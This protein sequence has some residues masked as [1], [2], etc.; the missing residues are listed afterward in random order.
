MK[1]DDVCVILNIH[2]EETLWRA[3]W[4]AHEGHWWF[5]PIGRHGDKK[6]FPVSKVIRNEGPRT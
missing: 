4:K 5:K 6:V 2:G 3:L 1:H